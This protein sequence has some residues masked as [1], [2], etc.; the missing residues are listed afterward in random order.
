[1][2][3]SPA[4]ASARA[5]G[6]PLALVLSGCAS[7]GSAVTHV[8]AERSEVSQSGD[9]VAINIARDVSNTEDAFDV[10]PDQLW[11]AIITIGDQ[12]GLKV[13]AIDPPHLTVEYYE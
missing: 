3:G 1:M 4:C 13:S 6:I 10:P 2:K 5:W 11:D 9:V 8:G 12:L 7:G